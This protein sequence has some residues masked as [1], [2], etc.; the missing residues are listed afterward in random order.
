[1]SPKAIVCQA[2]GIEAT[3]VHA[4]GKPWLEVDAIA[5][6]KSCVE[7]SIAPEPFRCPN[8]LSAAMD[9]RWIGKD[10]A[11]IGWPQEEDPA[12]A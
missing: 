3:R 1:M 4:N 6:N 9:A 2:C 10:G 5:F 8:M 12:S 7:L 11:W